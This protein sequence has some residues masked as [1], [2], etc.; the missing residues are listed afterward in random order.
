MF[1]NN[2]ITSDLMINEIKLTH[3][4][5][6]NND[7]IVSRHFFSRIYSFESLIF[8][9]QLISSTYKKPAFAYTLKD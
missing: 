2:A 7:W 6:S 8:Q 1:A 9:F 4:E 5:A 3:N